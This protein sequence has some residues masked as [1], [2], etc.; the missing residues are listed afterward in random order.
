M[1]YYAVFD[2]NVLVSSSEAVNRAL[3]LGDIQLY[4]AK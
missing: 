4:N 1:T 2:T 3:S